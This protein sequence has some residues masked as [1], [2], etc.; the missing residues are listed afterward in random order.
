M[1]CCVCYIWCSGQVVKVQSSFIPEGHN[2]SYTYF[3]CLFVVQV[4]SVNFLQ[5]YSKLMEYLGVF[6]LQVYGTYF[7]WVYRYTLFYTATNVHSTT[8]KFY[9]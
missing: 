6:L 7:P 5:L 9:N 8:D 3:P 1:P 2:F 4:K